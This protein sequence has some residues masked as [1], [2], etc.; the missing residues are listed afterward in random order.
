MLL[1][2]SWLAMPVLAAEPLI[3]RASV[4][5]GDTIEI[6]GQR[7]RIHGI[8]APEV[9][10]PCVTAAGHAWRCGRQAALKLAAAIG[11][12]PVRCEPRSRDRFRRVVAVCWR[13]RQDLGAWMVANGWAVASHQYSLDYADAEAHAYR[14]GRGIW[15]GS[16]EM[17]WDWRAAGRKR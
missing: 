4:I 14:A 13:S 17:L 7:I 12:G 15:A 16:F 11:D 8:D 2:M 9:R 6:H 5:D 3:G 1:G 10:Q